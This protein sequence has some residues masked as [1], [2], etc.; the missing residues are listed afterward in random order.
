MPP[1]FAPTIN[2]ELSVPVVKQ[3]V[4]SEIIREQQGDYAERLDKSQTLT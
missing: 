4:M 1:I 2:Y 3:I